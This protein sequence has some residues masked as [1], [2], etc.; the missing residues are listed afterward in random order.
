[1]LTQESTVPD[2]VKAKYLAA[3]TKD[4]VVTKAID[5]YPQ[6][7]IRTAM[8]NALERA[9]GLTRFPL[10]L[11]NALKFRKLT[12]ATLGGLFREAMA[13]RKQKG[14]TWAQLALAA[15]A[16]MLTRASMVEGKFE[17]GILPTG[18]VT[19][20]IA[21]LP[22]VA[23]LIQRIMQEAEATLSRLGVSDD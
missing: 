5:G 14:L 19:G 20:V 21:E 9:G 6:R 12:G 13:M 10:A 4:T 15:N 11:K 16:P 23:E 18:Q 3:K 7:V 22:T 2:A 17:V 8:I 1:L